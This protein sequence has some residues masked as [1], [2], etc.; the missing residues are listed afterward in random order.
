MPRR[1]RFDVE[2]RVIGKPTGPASFRMRIGTVR[3]RGP[4]KS[5]YGVHFDNGDTEWVQSHW[6]EPLAGTE[7][8]QGEITAE[9]IT[10]MAEF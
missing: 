3:E 8:R 6:I 2:D 5:E 9:R 10:P 1:F 4:G 7:L